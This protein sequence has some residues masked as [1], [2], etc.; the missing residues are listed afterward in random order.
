ML[1][2]HAGTTATS[3]RSTVAAVTPEASFSIGTYLAS[4][5]DPGQQLPV[6]NKLLGTLGSASL[7][8]VGYQG[9]ANTDV[10]INQLVTASGGLLTTSN[11]MT[12]S[13]SSQ[14]WLTIWSDAVANQVAPLNCGASPVPSP[15]NAAT[16]LTQLTGGGAMVPL[17]HLVTINTGSGIAA[18]GST[19]ASRRASCPPTSICCSSSRRRRS[20]RTA[21]A[22]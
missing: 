17:C 11:V 8:A 6:L 2:G 19:T 22:R 16:G 20:W 1:S 10:T 9:L 18:C 13:L 12:A 5:T 15:C 21:P 4:L 14:Q 7:T 3:D